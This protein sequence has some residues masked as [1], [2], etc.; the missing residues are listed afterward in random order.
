MGFLRHARYQVINSR[1]E[2]LQDRR[3]IRLAV[4]DHQINR[5]Y[6]PPQGAAGH[7]SGKQILCVGREQRYA[8]RRCHQRDRHCQMVHFVIRLDVNAGPLQILVDDHPQYWSRIRHADECLAGDVLWI[9]RLMRS[10]AVIAWQYDHERFLGQE[11]ERQTGCL[12][13]WSE[14]GYVEL[15]PHKSTRE[16]RRILA[17]DDDLYIGELV[18]KEADSFGQPIYLVSGQEAQSERRLGGLSG[19][20]GRFAGSID[21]SQRQSCMV[22]KDS[23]RGGQLDAASTA[24]DQL[25]AD[26]VFKIPDLTTE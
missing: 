7:G 4:P 24:N 12:R 3:R 10:E 25:S 18:S 6:I 9:D 11:L 23:T 2:S 14:E 5:G 1:E 13:F 21:L 26:L 19:A 8:A 17:G 22:E 15:A 20:P 16:V